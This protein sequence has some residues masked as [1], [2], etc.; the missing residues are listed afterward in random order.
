MKRERERERENRFFCILFPMKRFCDI[1]DHA[2]E[3]RE[4]LNLT[5]SRRSVVS[6]DLRPRKRLSEA[7]E[8]SKGSQNSQIHRKRQRQRQRQRHRISRITSSRK[9][10]DTANSGWEG[11]NLTYR[12]ARK[13][14]P[15]P[16]EEMSLTDCVD[17]PRQGGKRAGVRSSRTPKTMP[18]RRERAETVY[19]EWEETNFTRR[20]PRDLNL[21]PQDEMS[22]TEYA[23]LPP[24]NQHERRSDRESYPVRGRIRQESPPRFPGENETSRRDWPSRQ[25]METPCIYVDP[26]RAI[27]SY[28]DSRHI[29][30]CEP[31]SR[32]SAPDSCRD[33]DLLRHPS[34]QVQGTY[35]ETSSM[36]SAI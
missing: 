19:S 36:R 13:A 11:M 20:S 29:I 2:Q 7:S 28:P 22:L 3:A 31:L 35:A 30:K 15:V 17:F 9:R 1:I 16:Q 24:I 6:G 14:S 18:R 5:P 27:G 21:D 12:T 10:M 34:T 23:D 33:E 26:S 32:V 4:K 25:S 8:V